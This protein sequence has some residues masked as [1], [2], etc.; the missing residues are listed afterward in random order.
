V[1]VQIVDDPVPDL[2]V[3]VDDCTV[4]RIVRARTDD[5]CRALRSRN[6]S[7]L[8]VDL[9]RLADLETPWPR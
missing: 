9:G 1:L 7:V 4:R 2:P 8:H 6:R 5:D 3:P